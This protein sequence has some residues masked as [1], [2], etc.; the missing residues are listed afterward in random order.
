MKYHVEG[1]D[2]D[3]NARNLFRLQ[4]LGRRVLK[5]YQNGQ[6]LT[7][8]WTATEAGHGEVPSGSQVWISLLL[9]LTTSR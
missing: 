3:L 5:F 1:E 4:P 6:S 9:I 8:I 7:P 2:V